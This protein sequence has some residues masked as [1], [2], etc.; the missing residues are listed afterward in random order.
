M[1]RP[2]VDT[3]VDARELAED[4]MGLFGR[5]CGSACT[6]SVTASVGVTLSNETDSTTSLLR[7]ADDAM[8]QAKRDGKD[9][10]AVFDRTA[11]VRAQRRQT[12]ARRAPP[13]AR[14]R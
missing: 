9:R 12:L 11:R 3:L 2:G 4:A 13:G 8:Y 6:S 10:I 1:L 7:D 5:H 14:Q